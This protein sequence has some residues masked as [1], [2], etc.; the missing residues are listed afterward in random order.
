MT[1]LPIILI[2]ALLIAGCSRI[3]RNPD[4]LRADA[5]TATDPRAALRL[6]DS[7]PCAGLSETDRHFRDLLSV[8]ATDKAYITPDSMAVAKLEDAASYFGGTDCEA[9]ANYYLGRCNTDR[10]DL[11]TALIYFRK[12]LQSIRDTVRQSDLY[13]N[14]LSQTGRAFNSLY[15]F[16]EA[17]EYVGRTI[18]IERRMADTLNLIYDLQLLG[19]IEMH[20]GK[21]EGAEKLF[22]EARE[23]AG[24]GDTALAA[25]IDIYLAALAEKQGQYAEALRLIR[26]VPE[27]VLPFNRNLARAYAAEIY[28]KNDKA[29]TA[30]MHAMDILR[31]GNTDNRL[32]AYAVLFNPVIKSLL[33]PDTVIALTI[34]YHD[35]LEQSYNEHES[36]LAIVKTAFY[37]YS[38]ATEDRT[39]LIETENRSYRI[40]VIATAVIALLVIAI[41]IVI[42]RQLRMRRNYLDAQ[43]TIERLKGKSAD[44]TSEVSS[45]DKTDRDITG[46]P[47]LIRL[48]QEL[49]SSACFHSDDFWSRIDGIVEEYSPDF[50]A[51]LHRLAITPLTKADIEMA[52]F[53][54][55]RI[56]PSDMIKVLHLSKGS[57]TS[58]RTKLGRSLFGKKMSA[59]E[60]DDLIKSL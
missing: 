40:I 59:Q 46:C 2:T 20:R 51:K 43:L 11:N 56:R 23:L 32:S 31:S 24:I 13:G 41:A 55:C 3:S 30:R 12:A 53:I 22:R 52:L 49:E 54:K 39:R 48:Q 17:A 7:L 27:R 16:D 28:L 47:E 6:L 29:D 14:I 57:I 21:M 33:P 50:R 4:L 42:V 45:S 58:R 44:E 9:E 18:N 10:G 8:K 36:Q 5:L 60:I 15:I 25:Y 1:R 34:G 37:N 19:A 35:A 26:N 38:K